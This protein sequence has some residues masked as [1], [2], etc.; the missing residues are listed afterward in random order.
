MWGGG[1][2]FLVR[3][4]VSDVGSSLVC[5]NFHKEK[6]GLRSAFGER[7]I[8]GVKMPKLSRCPNLSLHP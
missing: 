3:Y 1:G 5:E 2:M 7:H 4:K 6:D 8:Y